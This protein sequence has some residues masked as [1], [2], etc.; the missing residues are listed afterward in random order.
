MQL[1][2]GECEMKILGSK[3]K[4]TEWLKEWEGFENITWEVFMGLDNRQQ[5]SFIDLFNEDVREGVL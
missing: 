5:M 1:K 4:F 3:S 2:K